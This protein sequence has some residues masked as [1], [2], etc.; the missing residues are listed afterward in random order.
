ME[1]QK[2]FNDRIVTIAVFCVALLVRMIHNAYI[3]KS[4]LYYLPLGGHVPYLVMA[5]KIAGGTILPFNGPFSLNSPL[6][7]YILA[8]EFLITGIDQLFF[9]RLFG[10]VLDSLTCVFVVM[11]ARRHFGTIASLVCGLVVAFYGPMIFYSSELIAVT[12][13]LFFITL[14]ILLLDSNGSVLL[15]LLSGLL[16]GIAVGTRPNLLILVVFIILV[17]F[18]QKREM[19][20]LKSSVITIGVILIIL[21]I[22]IANYIASGRFVLLTTSAGHNFYLGHNP[23]ATAGY[24]IPESL[25]GDIFLNMKRL[26][27][28][29]EGHSFEDDEISPYYIKKGLGYIFNHPKE[30]ILITGKKALA[31][32]N[33]YEAT[34]YVNYYFQKALSPVLAYAIGFGILFPFAALGIVIHYR[35]SLLMMPIVTSFLTIFIF[36]YIARLRMPMIPF[37]TI[38]A[39]GAFSTMVSYIHRR[40]W[41]RFILGS[42]FVLGVCLLSNLNLADIDTSNEW[43]KVG[44][45]FRIQKRYTDAER[46]FLQAKKNNPVNVNTYLN[47][48]VLYDA[49]GNHEKAREMRAVA[50]TL[51][52]RGYEKRFIEDL[53]GR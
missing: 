2:I 3:M 23:D 52:K 19:R 15:H 46:A 31:S 9:A 44:I 40:N 8:A 37:L 17:P 14:A 33:D 12:Y 32:I 28:K 41:K 47:L 42:L 39:V 35:R 25:D 26:A 51:K 48:G 24:T 45:A 30:E 38:F 4:P 11:I 18:Y 21:P 50:D 10:M 1:R 53:Q 7:P 13:T 29:I 5:E 34:T 36:F 49:T 20:W 43:N 27:E 16:L 6:Y 22:T